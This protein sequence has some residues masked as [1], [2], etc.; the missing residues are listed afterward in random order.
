MR[1]LV[2]TVKRV[3]GYTEHYVA[4]LEND[5]PVKDELIPPPVRVEIHDEGGSGYLLLRFGRDGVCLAD[6][7]H[8][9]VAE[10]KAQAQAEFAILDDDWVLCS[11]EG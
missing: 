6:T 2:A 7:W 5:E 4:H 3:T 9:T 8:L 11:S 1:L 10:A